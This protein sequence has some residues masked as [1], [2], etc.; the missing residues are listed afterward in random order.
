MPAGQGVGASLV[1]LG[2]DQKRVAMEALRVAAD[3]ETKR[4]AENKV[5]A[6]QDKA[7]K[8]QLGGSLGG[9]AGAAIGAQYGAAAGPWG[10]LIGGLVGSVAGGYL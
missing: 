7:A 1:G 5:L 4:N 3:Q 8:Q 9:L 10:A 2:L 6:A